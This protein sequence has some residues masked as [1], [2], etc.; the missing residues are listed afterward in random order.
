MN[1]SETSMASPVAT[2]ADPYLTT[3]E[4]ANRYR[5]EPSTVRYWRHIGD[6]P[7][8]VKIGRR[9]LYRLSECERW[10][11]EREAEQHGAA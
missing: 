2:H 6:G 3:A 9:I 10:E 1:V 4:V 8:G 7:K 11:R 5:T